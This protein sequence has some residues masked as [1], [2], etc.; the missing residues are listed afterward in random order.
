MSFP[1]QVVVAG[2]RL[3]PTVDEVCDRLG[4]IGGSL[5]VWR[6]DFSAPAQT[7]KRVADQIREMLTADGFEGGFGQL[8]L[9]DSV[10]RFNQAAGP[11]T[12]AAPQRK[13]WIRLGVVLAEEADAARLVTTG[14]DS[15][16]IVPAVL[17]HRELDRHERQ[18]VVGNILGIVLEM[19]RLPEAR[20]AVDAFR[21]RYG[22]TRVTLVQTARFHA[23]AVQRILARRL[24]SRV[25]E[26]MQRALGPR[27]QPPYADAPSLADDQVIEG[28][29]KRARQLGAEAAARVVFDEEHPVKGELLKRSEAEARRLPEAIDQAVRAQSQDVR[30]C[31]SDFRV[32]LREY[33]DHKLAAGSFGALR[34]LAATLSHLRSVL[35]TRVG[36]FDEALETYGSPLQAAPFEPPDVA[37]ICTAFDALELERSNQDRSGFLFGAWALLI[38]TLVA[39]ALHPLVDR[40]VVPGGAAGLGWQALAHHPSLLSALPALPVLLVAAILAWI[41]SRIVAAKLLSLEEAVE[42]EMASYRR[43]WS[44]LVNRH[45]IQ[46]GRLMQARLL[47]GA[48]ETIAAEQQ[49]LQAVIGMVEQLQAAYRRPDDASWD[50][51]SEFDLEIELP[52]DFYVRAGQRADPAEVLDHYEERMRSEQWRDRLEFMN[53]SSVLARCMTLYREFQ[54][55]IPFATRDELREVAVEPTRRALAEMKRKLAL[56]VPL[57]VQADR[58]FVVP[59]RLLGAVPPDHVTHFELF[60]GVSDLFAALTQPVSHERSPLR[61]SVRPDGRPRSSVARVPPGRA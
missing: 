30:A 46:I 2:E 5:A 43:A 13:P 38:A 49:R 4:T 22:A 14:F 23:P 3:A 50:T 53:A 37:A 27:E 7:P 42:L 15:V 59:E 26:R 51:G 10:E 17:L 29:S 60:S 8:L 61:E 41:R 21:R 57:E 36:A 1:V 6:V 44:E 28:L 58:F 56:F 40:W 12:G 35:R 47:R 33:V 19:A 24:A 34:P 18:R 11:V 48:I 55:K 39:C 20:P 31:S 52:E 16:H 25:T 32:K 9:A 54:E 45:V